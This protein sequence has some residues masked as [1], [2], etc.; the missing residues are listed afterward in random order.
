MLVSMQ[1]IIRDKRLHEALLHH[2]FVVCA[3]GSLEV[4]KSAQWPKC[5]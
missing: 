1:C 4:N 5:T 2:L 3:T